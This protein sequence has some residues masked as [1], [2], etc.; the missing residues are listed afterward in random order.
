[1]T[2]NH[3]NGGEMFVFIR[4]ITKRKE[5]DQ[6]I[7]ENQKKFQ[8]LIERS[9]DG[10]YVLQNNQFVFINPMFTKILGYEISD[11]S[12]PDF[13]LEQ[14]MPEE[15]IK[16]IRERMRKMNM[17]EKLSSRYG[18][19]C[20]TKAGDIVD[21][22]V[23]IGDIEWEGKPAIMG[24][25]RDESERIR[26]Q[27]ELVEALKKSEESQ[28]LKSLFLS[29][30]S[31]ELR[32]PLN[33]IVGFSDLIR[34]ETHHLLDE[35]MLDFFDV[36]EQSSNRLMNTVQNILNISLLETGEIDYIPKEVDLVDIVNR[37]VKMV[38]LD[39]QRKNIELI[40]ENRTESVPMTADENLLFNALTNLIDNA[41]KYTEHGYVSISLQK[42]CE[43]VEMAIS[44][45]GV[46]MSDEYLTKLFDTFS[47]ESQG[48]NKKYQGIG[49]G[50]AIAK[51]TFDLH[52]IDVTVESKKGTGTTFTLKFLL[53]S[54]E[55]GAQA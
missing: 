11:I 38:E 37:S 8:E 29:N 25:I 30:I 43:F 40:Y 23:S 17:G 27:N 19:K 3:K 10:I 45:S 47:Q 34:H 22:N 31:H 44:D 26:Y 5:A 36:I 20:Y 51:R 46:G 55:K 33:A 12:G 9:N 49:L 54:S 42:N 4:D 39:A 18:F 48:F 6:K 35:S 2:S 21:I 1:M 24:I 16:V 32:T 14:I 15:G 52:N 53:T 28:R 13:N 41:I 50:L 7:T